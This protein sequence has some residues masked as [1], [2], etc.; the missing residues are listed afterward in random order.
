MISRWFG[1][2][3]DEPLG[4][5]DGTVEEIRYFAAPDDHGVFVTDARLIKLHNQPPKPGEFDGLFTNHVD[6]LSFLKY[7]YYC[8]RSYN[9]YLDPLS[10]FK[11]FIQRGISSN[12][13]GQVFDCKPFLIK[14]QLLLSL[15][16]LLTFFSLV[17]SVGKL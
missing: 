15:F 7:P 9:I 17:P 1:I 11:I 14:S 8:Y 4:R 5:H 6:I 12:Y 3:L 13:F 10:I 2:E 16:P